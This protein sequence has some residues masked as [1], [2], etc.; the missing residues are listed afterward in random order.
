MTHGFPWA[1]AQVAAMDADVVV[2]AGM[3]LSQRIGF[4]MAPRF[5][6]DA[7]FIQID[8]V[9]EA[10]GRN[11][12]IDVPIIG[13]AKRTLENLHAALVL[14]S[15]RTAWSTSWVKK[16]IADRMARVEEISTRDSQKIHPIQI[17]TDLMRKLPENAIFVADG[18]DVYNWMSAT[19]RMRSERSYLDHYPLGSMGV[20]TPL[21]I[22]AA[23]GAREQAEK[24]G[25]QARPVV[26]VTGDGSFG[27]YLA[28]F[29]SAV[30]A[31][32][33]I[34]C[35]IANDGAWGTEKNAQLNSKGMTVNCDL[36]Q[37]DYH[38]I[39]DVFGCR[40]EKVATK[41]ALLPALDRALAADETT[42][43][44]VITDPDAGL[45]RKKDPRL[46]MVT[47]ED[48]RTSLDVHHTTEVA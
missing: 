36:G 7:K 10:L 32:L 46:Q 25:D 47:F 23:A 20:G 24:S 16:R 1:L 21:A 22:G 27:F 13:D 48:L 26:L 2:T 41:A 38:L 31:G 28:E 40:G 12:H 8:I 3:R 18:A 9:A 45:E 11:R 4:G 37:C 42:I 14:N 34:V 15:D 35:V 30:L 6:Q 5:N 29:N 19:M 17:G 43:I 33:K 44:N 39:A